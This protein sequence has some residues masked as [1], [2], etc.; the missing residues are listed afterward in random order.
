[1]RPIVKAL[2]YKL[3]RLGLRSRFWCA[4][5]FFMSLPDEPVPPALLRFRVSESLSVRE[6]LRIGA[7][8]ANLVRH[9]VNLMG[10]DLVNGSRVLDFGCGCGRTLRWFLASG[11]SAEFHGVDVDK[12]AID[13][14]NRNLHRGHFLATEPLPPLPYP[15]QHFDLVYCLSVFT[16]LNEPMQDAWL[17]EL[18]RVLKPGGAL[19]LTVF[20]A[21]AAKKLGPADKRTLRDLGFVHKRSKKLKGLVSDWYQTS[22]HSR[23]YVLDRMSERFEDVR[24][25]VVPDGLQ[26]VVVARKGGC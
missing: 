17:A 16:H 24:Y 20:G 23:E 9:H 1:L 21:T 18:R 5:H 13:W 22:W 14:C 2:Y 15:G 25:S 7:G 12:E 11:I 26:D 6:F 3:F 8:S 19:L 10:I 4:D